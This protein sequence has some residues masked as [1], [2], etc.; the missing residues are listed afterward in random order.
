MSNL[1]IKSDWLAST[2]NADDEVSATLAR[3]KILLGGKNITEYR[4]Y[5]KSDSTLEDALQIPVYYLAE[6]LAE[7]WWVILFEPRKDEHMDDSDFTSRHS[8]LAAQHGFPLPALTIMPFGRSIRLNNA[9]RQSPYAN[10]R[11]TQRAFADMARS[12]VERILSTFVDRTVE[13]LRSRGVIDTPLNGL[14]CLAIIQSSRPGRAGSFVELVGSLG[15]SP[16]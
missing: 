3:V 5:R 1:E 14:Y 2:K 4:Q 15:I 9:P 12:D 10:V 8:L 13:Q 7:N 11:F 6:W 16:Q